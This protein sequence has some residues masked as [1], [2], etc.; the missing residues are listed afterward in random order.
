MNRAQSYSY[1][2][3]HRLSRYH[4]D[5]SY[6]IDNNGIENVIRLLAVGRR[7]Y[8]FCGNHDAA[9]NAAVMYSLLGCCKANDID[10]REIA[11]LLYPKLL[12]ISICFI[13]S[14]FI[15]LFAIASV[16]LAKQ[17][18]RSVQR[19]SIC[20]NVTQY[21]YLRGSILPE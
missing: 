20:R 10:S 2:L 11:F 8:L 9:E 21:F 7:N 13:T 5:G 3:F 16:F 17:R 14:I 1:S 15:V 6:L 18:N 4:L 19:G 12:K